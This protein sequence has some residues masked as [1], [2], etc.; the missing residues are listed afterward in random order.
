MAGETPLFQQM[1]DACF[2]ASE[3]LYGQSC[4]WEKAGGNV[5]DNV[6]FNDP[7]EEEQMKLVG[8][9]GLNHVGY[10]QAEIP[11]PTI[12]YRHGV[13]SGLW[14]KVM[15]DIDLQYIN[16]EGKRYVCVKARSLFDGK[17]YIV[18]VQEAQQQ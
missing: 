5:T 17:T 6:L 16:T 14:E 7:T 8:G 15:E 12:E 1:Q 13:F 2:K 3:R 9:R 10:N 11:V 4:T 18:V